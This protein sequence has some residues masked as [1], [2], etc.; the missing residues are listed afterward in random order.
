MRE[1]P[2]DLVLGGFEIAEPQL[3][4]MA[5]EL[6][7]LLQR[8]Q[9]V[10]LQPDQLLAEGDL[11]VEGARVADVVEIIQHLDG[12]AV[13]NPRQPQVILHY[14]AEHR[15]R[16]ALHLVHLDGKSV[17]NGVVRSQTHQSLTFKI[18]DV[19]VEPIRSELFCSANFLYNSCHLIYLDKPKLCFL[20]T[21]NVIKLVTEGL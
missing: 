3:G 7:R 10:D 13:D 8:Q 9:R 15:A 5:L 1:V 20:H 4:E 16:E 18:L 11:Q 19:E 2:V 17:K 6:R 12:I 21:R 14:F